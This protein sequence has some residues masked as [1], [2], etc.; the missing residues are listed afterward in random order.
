M[1]ILVTGIILVLTITAGSAAAQGFGGQWLDL[2]AYKEK[3][4]EWYDAGVEQAK[5]ISSQVMAGASSSIPKAMQALSNANWETTDVAWRKLAHYAGTRGEIRTAADA[6]KIFDSI[7]VA[8]RM[9]GR[10]ALKG[11]DWSHIKSYINGGLNSPSNGVFEKA[12]LNR[13]RG[14]LN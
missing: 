14:G 11:Y 3:T 13:S 12:S 6:K 4:S 2:Q 9:K 7:P 8:I 10:E 1:Q 5:D